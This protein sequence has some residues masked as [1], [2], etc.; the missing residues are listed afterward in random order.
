VA[1]SA[2]FSASVLRVVGYQPKGVVSLD[3]TPDLLRV[4]VLVTEGGTAGLSI[5]I[6]Q[7]WTRWM[8]CSTAGSRRLSLSP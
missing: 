2:G 3:V 6:V 5:T 1:A 7:N 4:L 8:N